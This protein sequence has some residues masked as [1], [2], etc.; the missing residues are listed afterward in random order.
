[1]SYRWD[2]G[3]WDTKVFWS[4]VDEAA[5]MDKQASEKQKVRWDQVSPKA[6]PLILS[7]ICAIPCC[8]WNNDPCD[9]WGKKEQL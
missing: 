7:S 9:L 1:M 5:D 8:R 4:L 3:F 2:L 6:Y